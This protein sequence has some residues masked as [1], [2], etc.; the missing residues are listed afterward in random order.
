MR[1]KSLISTALLGLAALPVAAQ[2]LAIQLTLRQGRTEQGLAA[3]V[4]KPGEEAKWAGP[5]LAKAVP[6]DPWGNALYSDHSWN[7]ITAY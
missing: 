2:R 6:K 4:T 7:S 1:L 3:L 5:Y